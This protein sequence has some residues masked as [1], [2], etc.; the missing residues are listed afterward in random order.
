VIVLA[1]SMRAGDL[2]AKALVS[3]VKQ[4]S[5]ATLP[6]I[7]EKELGAARVENGRLI[8]PEGKTKAETFILLG[9]GE[10]TRKLGLSLD[11]LGAGGILLQSSVPSGAG[12]RGIMPKSFRR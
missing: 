9:E 7:T 12:F 10:L 3:H 11:G 5:G 1:E 8:P 6:T 4:M 2:T